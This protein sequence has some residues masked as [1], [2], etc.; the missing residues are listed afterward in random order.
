MR[1]HPSVFVQFSGPIVIEQA[2]EFD[3]SGTQAVRALREE[4]HRGV[5][6]QQPGDDH[7]RPG[8]GRCHQHRAQNPE[9]GRRQLRAAT[10]VKYLPRSNSR[11]G[12]A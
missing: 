8:P 1:L 7:Y 11:D 3:Y 12:F 10:D 9:W 2:A 6:E 5:L 4:G